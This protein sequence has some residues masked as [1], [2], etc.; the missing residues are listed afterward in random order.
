M[1][2]Q[3]TINLRLPYPPSVN[4]GFFSRV[5]IQPNGRSFVQ[6]GV[7]K[8]GKEYF[9]QVVAHLKEAHGSYSPDAGR[10]A[11]AI[12]ATMPDRRKRDID[13]CLKFLVDSLSHARVLLD[14]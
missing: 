6:R 3:M 4:H 8:A 7:S 1:C 2:A 12:V 13:N 9:A 5:I 14:D 11:V 10:F